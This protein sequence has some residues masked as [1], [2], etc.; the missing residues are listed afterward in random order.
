MQQQTCYQSLVLMGVAG[1]GKST[2]AR[3]LAERLGWQCLEGDDFHSA[4]GKQMMAAGQPLAAALR[5]QWVDRLCNVLK[6]YQQQQKPVVL[7]YS[8]LIKTQREQIRAAAWAP[9][10]V[11]LKGS[12]ELLSQRLAERKNHFMPE[13]MLASQLATMQEPEQEADVLILD[14]SQSRE[15]LLQQ[16]LGRLIG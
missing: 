7:S 2:M 14:I 16:V 1:S 12:A 5:Q 3:L 15:Q 8:G 11:Y 13:S 10:F 4:E 6:Q 9:L